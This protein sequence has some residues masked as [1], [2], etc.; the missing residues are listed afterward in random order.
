MLKSDYSM[1]P[2]KE[3]LKSNMHI[4]QMEIFYEGKLTK[5]TFLIKNLFVKVKITP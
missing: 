3:E 5:I 4:S 2:I 1:D